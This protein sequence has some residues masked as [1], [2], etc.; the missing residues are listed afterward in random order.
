MVKL[1]VLCINIFFLLPTLIFFIA[2]YWYHRILEVESK[3]I[4]W[5]S[6]LLIKKKKNERKYGPE[7]TCWILWVIQDLITCQQSPG[8]DPRACVWPAR[9]G[10]PPD[11]G[12]C[13]VHPEPA[14]FP[15]APGPCPGLCLALQPSFRL[16]D[17]PDLSAQQSRSPV[18]SVPFQLPAPHCM[19]YYLVCPL[20]STLGPTQRPST[21]SQ[22]RCAQGFGGAVHPS[23]CPEH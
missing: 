22:S 7:R 6:L 2:L 14:F 4:R 23:S 21:N 12:V 10:P 11:S 16:L 15:P 17:L 19:A 9:E 20:W 3:L 1:S 13:C 18:C 8:L 5:F